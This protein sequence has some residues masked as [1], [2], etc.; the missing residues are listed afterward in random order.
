VT[1]PD[2]RAV[3]AGT[4]SVSVPDSVE[5][6]IQPPSIPPNPIIPILT[7]TDPAVRWLVPEFIAQ[8]SLV[9]YAGEPGVGKSFLWYA[10]GLA[11]ATGV[12]LLGYTPVRP[13]RVLYFDQENSRP[14]R[15]QYLRWAWEGLERPSLER[16]A[17]NFWT[18]H[19]F[20]GTADWGARA[21]QAVQVVQ[22]DLII[23]DTATPCC[24]ILDENDNGIATQAVNK[25]RGVMNVVPHTAAMVVLKHSRIITED[26]SQDGQ[27]PR[28]TIRGAKAWV[29][30]ADAVWFHVRAAGALRPDGLAN[31]YIMPAKTRAFGLRRRIDIHPEWTPDRR[32]LK[33]SR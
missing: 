1:T 14:D 26:G 17:A 13:L 24:A 2:H 12:P 10:L 11:C 33:L 6:S 27:E 30:M 8:G 15:D 22:P 20:L 5:T 28:R 21:S 32:G 31:T 29:G 7:G 9:V 19:F 23:L 18:Q 3:T 25:L 16:V 4:T